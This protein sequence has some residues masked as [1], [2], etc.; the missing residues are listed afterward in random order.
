VAYCTY[1]GQQISDAAVM[2]PKC[3][4]P[5]Q[6]SAAPGYRRTESLAV[7]SLVLGIAGFVVCPFVCSIIAVVLGNQAKAKLRADPG[8]E[9]EG[10]ARAGV[11]LG[12]VGVGVGVLLIVGF[13]AAVMSGTVDNP[14]DGIDALRRIG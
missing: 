9:G 7:A 12:W 1:C 10:M 2:C 4:H 13:I 8:L 6:T 14:S 5:Q 3:G 11:I